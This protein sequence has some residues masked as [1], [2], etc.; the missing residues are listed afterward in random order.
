MYVRQIICKVCTPCVICREK[1]AEAQ[2]KYAQFL[3]IPYSERQE[4]SIYLTVFHIYTHK[5]THICM[6]R[7]CMQICHYVKVFTFFQFYTISRQRNSCERRSAHSILLFDLPLDFMHS[8]LLIS[9]TLHIASLF[10]A[11]LLLFEFPSVA[12]Q[13]SI[14]VWLIFPNS[15]S[16]FCTVFLFALPFFRLVLLIFCISIDISNWLLVISNS[17]V[18]R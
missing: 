2:R 5:R 4:S 7:Y 8:S 3:F 6:K 10:H 15:Q 18:F 9:P 14:D 11:P 16:F 13:F 17:F 12:R 1:N